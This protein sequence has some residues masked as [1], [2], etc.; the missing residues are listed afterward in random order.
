M[1]DVGD[2]LRVAVCQINPTVGDLDGNLQLALTALAEAEEA[3]ADVA[4]MPEMAITGY[5][6]EDLL[7]RPAFVADS[8]AAVQEFASRT[9][10]CAAVIGF[11]DGAT[12]TKGSKGTKGK[13]TKGIKGAE[14]K[15]ADQVEH[16]GE[17][18]GYKTGVWNALAVCADGDILGI[19]HK[20][21]L[22][23]YDVFDELRYFQRGDL[24][25]ILHNFAGVEVGL[26]VCED[27]WIANGPVSQLGKAGAQLVFNINGSPYR[28][29]KV[30]VREQVICERVAET[31]VPILYVNLVG[32]QDELV[33]DGGSFLVT[34]TADGPSVTLRC[35]R[36]TPLVDVFDIELPCSPSLYANW[37]V[38]R[39]ISKPRGSNIAEPLTGFAEQ[40][41][42][43]RLG[44]RDY[45]HKS[46]F[47]EV[48][49]GLSGGVDS[50]LTA[51]IAVDALGASQVHGVLMPSRYS[52]DHSVT[53]AKALAAN[54]DINTLTIGIEAA[55]KALTETL[56]CA[57]GAA[58]GGGRA[59]LGD[60]TDQNLQSR[61]RG[62]VLMA[63]ANEHGW[64]V[65]T[66]G[67]KSEVAVGYST[68]YGDTAGA[69]A[70]IK[71]VWK[72]DV[73][74]LC[75]WRNQQGQMVIPETVLSKAPSAELRPNQRDDQSLPPYTT[76]DPVLRAYVEDDLGVEQ[77]VARGLGDRD[78]VYQVCAA[79]DGAEFKRR[80]SPLGVRLS[81]KAFGRDR[82]MPIVN[83]YRGK[84]PALQ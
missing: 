32:G 12:A 79:V 74:E 81:G 69:F 7:L 41:H 38:V 67:N 10:R 55:H 30:R 29:G 37:P 20:R 1:A 17:G 63:L 78:L 80:Q 57:L 70:V 9:G 59:N 56:L 8:R 52:S 27:S 26:T 21:H 82:R 14:R 73:Y 34:P 43:L 72:L 15:V 66:T 60:L 84:G 36:F 31:G 35:E 77:I 48:C 24:P 33:F 76:L 4:V 68:L 23:N 22:P 51:A 46:G 28:N 39:P 54:L 18:F 11:A 5:P 71:D 3:N 13:A 42:A 25:P 47:S 58:A 62:L 50:S 65:L 75:R 83:R 40:W 19:H 53:D 64:L 16:D 61:I 49:V 44:T 6:P 45:V 2:H